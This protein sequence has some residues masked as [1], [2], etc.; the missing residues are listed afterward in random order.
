MRKRVLA[1]FLAFAGLLAGHGDAAASSEQALG[2]A[3]ILCDAETAR[4]ENSRAIPS[5][6][7]KA[8]SLAETG[9]WDKAEQANIT[10]PWTITALGKGNYFP[11]RQSAL[12]FVRD[13]KA[14]G[15][16]N[17]DVGCMQINLYY[18]GGA[19]ANLEQAID[20]A[21]NIEY[22]ADYLTGLYQST[23]SWTQAAAYY[24]STTPDRAKAYKMKVL[25]YW[26]QE[27]RQAASPGGKSIDYTRMEKLNNNHKEAMEKAAADAPGGQLASWRQNRNGGLD[28]TTLA[29]MR[30]AKAKAEWQITYGREAG[31]KTDTFAEK[32]RM[33]LKKWRLSQSG[34][35]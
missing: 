13:L 12:D 21:S 25:K 10:W 23:R 24:H 34:A 20:P 19:F 16:N 29:A 4:M 17:I 26:N 9:R 35:S 27:R 28:M 30:R 3:S 7:L 8:I 11:D 18:H 32:R 1:V 5:H 6:L 33:Q 2:N 15:I 22:A 14:R 31:S